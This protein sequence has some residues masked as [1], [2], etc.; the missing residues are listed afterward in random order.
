MITGCR[1]L[2]VGLGTAKESV[3][4]LGVEVGGKISAGMEENRCYRR[5]FD[6][7]FEMNILMMKKRC[8]V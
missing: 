8:S 3:E 2:S 7:L 6:F 1:K 5:T 4:Q